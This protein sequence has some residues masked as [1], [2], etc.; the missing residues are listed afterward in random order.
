MNKHV[1]ILDCTIR[2]GSYPYNKKLGSN[3]M[4]SI[5]K[6]LLK[7]KIDYVEVGFLEDSSIG[8]DYP[9]FTD[10][11]S[12]EK[13][14]KLET[15]G[16]SEYTLLADISRYS[17]KNLPYYQ[18]GVIKN[19]RITFFKHEMYVLEE[20]ANQVLEKGYNVFIQPVDTLGYTS[21]EL[22]DLILIINRINP[23]VVSIVDTF[24]SMYHD[25]LET[26]FQLFNKRL[27]QQIIVGFHSHNNL[28]LSS[29]LS[30]YFYKMSKNERKVIIDSTLMGMGRGAGNTPT[31]LL[32]EF[33]NIKEGD[34]YDLATI[35]N[36]SKDYIEAFKNK[37]DWS[38]NLVLFLSGKYSS[39]VNVVNYLL[40]RNISD[41]FDM[42]TILEK[43]GDNK[44]RYN[45]EIIDEI[46]RETIKFDLDDSISLA[47]LSNK[48]SNRSVLLLLPGNSIIKESEKIRKVIIAKDPVIINVN[49][50]NSDYESDFCFFSNKSRMRQNIVY[51][52]QSNQDLILTSNLMIMNSELPNS[53]YWIDIN[54]IYFDKGDVGEVSAIMLLRLLD[55]FKIKSID[56]A[57]FDGYSITNDTHN[58]FT[59]DFEFYSN[60][61]FYKQIND[62][63][64][65]S[66]SNFL[67][68]RVSNYNITLITSSIF[69][70]E[71]D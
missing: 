53:V 67:K 5:I 58:Y 35:V 51:I 68:T 29:A 15:V 56:I 38:Y 66:L 40:G 18:H 4:I 42:I 21:D 36:T 25:D 45:Y 57:G 17:T 27:N 6:G 39:H 43:L 26:L 49:F 10:P 44:K 23:M 30:Q 70:L 62:L 69:K 24:G 50:V 28:Q 12:A 13:T 61:D 46:Y 55:M 48:L 33:I 19:I 65:N 8:D 11:I 7:S 16:L 22:Y 60:N 41:Y 32:V 1:S 9:V 14:L 34:I 64:Q 47:Y 71:S 2:D 59:S 54:K 20:Y 37:Y 31:E 52:E 3:T 63:L